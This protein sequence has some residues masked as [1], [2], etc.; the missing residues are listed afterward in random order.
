MYG[1][2]KQP[3]EPG[4]SITVKTESGAVKAEIRD[5]YQG[6]LAFQGTYEEGDQICIGVP[7]AN[8]FYKIRIDD[9]MDDELVYL[10]VTELIYEIPFGEKKKA[11]NKK[12]F[13][14]DRHYLTVRSAKP[15][16]INC[17]RNLAKNVIDQHGERGCFPHASANVETRGESVF[18]ARN[19]IDGV[20]AN[21]SHGSWPYE[22][23]GINKNDQ[24]E[25]KLEFGR[26]VDIDKL[27]LYTRADFPH[28]NWWVSATVTFSDGERKELK[29]EKSDRP[30]VF[31]IQK[32]GI[33]WVTLSE[34]VKSGDPSPFPALTQ[35][36]IYGTESCQR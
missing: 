29:M 17:Y 14:G 21:H 10:T 33:E 12:S 32:T 35:L 18:A 16:E 2:V 11:Y 1:E 3:K 24:A 20:L 28:D 30:H 26:K 34:L 5:R 25:M 15:Y 36:E 8:R 7:E 23:W 31:A 6:I 19:A 4:F 13:A 22:S 27:L 9:T